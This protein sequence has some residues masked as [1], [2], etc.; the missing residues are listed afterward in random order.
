M[1]LQPDPDRVTV[2]PVVDPH[3]RDDRRAPRAVRHPVDNGLSVGAWSVSTAHLDRRWGTPIRR[4]FTGRNRLTHYAHLRS[5]VTG[6]QLRHD[7]RA[8][9]GL[10]PG[11][12]RRAAG[13]WPC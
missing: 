5:L 3:H 2:E 10:R 4:G 6:N 7:R 13:E 11:G 8:A 1:S 12:R 9:A